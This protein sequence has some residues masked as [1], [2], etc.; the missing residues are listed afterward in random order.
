MTLVVDVGNSAIKWARLSADGTLRTPH[1]QLHRCADLVKRLAEQWGRDVPQDAP[2]IACN[3][4]AAEVVAAVEEAGRRARLQTVR[5]LQSQPGFDGPIA[6]ANGYRNPAQLGADRWHCMLGACSTASLD[7]TRSL[8]IVNAGTATTIDCVDARTGGARQGRFVGKFVGGVIAPGVRLMLESLAL[9][10]AG[11]PHADVALSDHVAD[12][13]D[14]TEAAIHTGVLDAQAGLVYRVWHRFAGHLGA[15]P[16]L[17][18]TGGHAEVLVARL[19]IA[20]DIEHNLVLRG[21][22]LRARFDL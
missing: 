10:T 21:L 22:A 7:A 15:E 13:P 1:V 16:R 3:V 19:S 8:V 11:L 12:F 18:V 6:L 5:W 9:R 20:A 17:F 4:A 14:N 2:V